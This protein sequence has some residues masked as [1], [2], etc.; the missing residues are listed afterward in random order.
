MRA[1]GRGR[2]GDRDSESEK[3]REREREKAKPKFAHGASLSLSLSLCEN[4]FAVKS[5]LTYRARQSTRRFEKRSPPRPAET[6]EVSA[7]AGR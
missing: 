4:L 2:G 3:E 1:G 7:A 6:L 5:A